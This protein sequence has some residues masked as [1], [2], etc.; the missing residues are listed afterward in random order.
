M[1]K[2]KQE[3]KK[4]EPASFMSLFM[5]T[6]PSERIG[7]IVGTIASIISGAAFPFFLLFLADVTTLFDE[8]KRGETVAKGWQ[9]CWKL[10][11]VGGVLWVA[12]KFIVNLDFFGTYLWNT[13]G[14]AQS[15]RLKK[16]YYKI[17]L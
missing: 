6:T 16:A 15:I 8:N 9:F 13:I 17:L 14:S 7:L 11:I 10:F 4:L 12:R 5:Y 3:D 1:S 2:D